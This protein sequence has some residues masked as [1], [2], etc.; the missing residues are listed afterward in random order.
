MNSD[1]TVQEIDSVEYGLTDIQRNIVGR[2]LEAYGR[3]FWETNSEK[4]EKLHS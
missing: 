4:I 3:G 2:M 1:R